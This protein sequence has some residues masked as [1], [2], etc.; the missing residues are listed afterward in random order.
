MKKLTL[1]LLLLASPL[2]ASAANLL[3]VYKQAQCSDPTFQQAVSQRLSTKEGVPISLSSL[4][5]NILLNFNP[6][7]QRQSFSGSNLQ[8]DI[9]GNTI[10]P[11]N[12][13]QRAYSLSLALTQTVF[14]YS[15][16]A[17]LQGELATSKGA[18]A[19]LNSALQ[20]LMIRTA[21]AYLAIL[22]NEDK[23]RYA[24]A[25]K[26]AY[27]E[28]LDQAQQ[29]YDV[30]LK[31]ITDVYT[32]QARYDS[33][34][35]DVIAK[36]TD[37]ANSRENLRVITG[38]YYPDL[39]KLSERLPLISPAPANIESWVHTAIQ[40]NWAIKTA[41]YTAESKLQNIHQ[42]FAGHLPTAE[43][44]SSLS[45]QY[46]NNINGYQSFNQR[47]GP[48][49]Q[50]NKTIGVNINFPIF[51]GGGVVAN[52]NQATYDLQVSQQQFE[53]TLRDT[54]NQT[55]QS[56]MNV[57]SGISQIQAD[58]QA[59]KS[60]IS[61]LEGMEASYKVGTETLVNVLNQQ[62]KLFESQ[63]EYATDR[64]AF[65]NNMLLLKQAAGTLSFEDLYA[66]NRWLSDDEV[67]SSLYKTKKMKYYPHIKAAHAKAKPSKKAVAKAHKKTKNLAS[68][69]SHV[70]KT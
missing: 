10:S 54:I 34:V 20:D 24:E 2:S 41:Q 52:T 31:T 69:Q 28:Q 16:Y 47:N 1:T 18:D 30:G 7:I 44:Q 48:G 26:V 22:E 11:R 66:L 42:Q 37:V 59:I 35:A 65:V 56:Y 25:T 40:Q 32:A 53:Q 50:N 33:S 63:S 68:H 62:Q 49:V 46:T 13:T 27:K 12:N 19:T 64:Y 23:L 29:Q 5:P 58:R 43:L 51:S 70:L 67:D 21:K 15:Q 9:D 4:L 57:I 39:A 60:N 8:T 6:S 45:R 61:S 14:D 36:E 17:N 38:K 3:E 55:R